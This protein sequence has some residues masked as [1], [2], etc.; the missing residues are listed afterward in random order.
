MTLTVAEIAAFL[1]GTVEGDE[2]V[3]ISGI[4][5]IREAGP[6]E[7]SFV[8]NPRYASDVADTRAGAVIVPKDWAKPAPC[9]LIRVDSPDRAFALAAERF[10][11]PPIR[12]EPGVHST[13]VV[14]PDVKL[15]PSVHVGPHCVIEPGCRIGTGCVLG[16]GVYLGHDCRL[17]DEVRLYPGVSVRERCRLGHRVI[18]HNGAVIGSD[19]FGYSVDEH[20]VRTKI[21]QIGIVE[22]GDDVEIGAN[23]TIDRARFGRTVIGRGTKIDNLVQIAHN[24]VIGENSVIV[25]QVGI[26]GSTSLGARTILGGQVG[27]IGHVKLG[28]GVIVGAQA[29]VTKN[30]PAGSFVSGYPAMPHARATRIQ[31]L[32]Q[33]LPEWRDQ[34]ADLEKRLSALEKKG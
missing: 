9:T 28:D 32:T 4:A 1:N 33:C 16:A 6:R 14:A 34:L 17:G 3:E 26:A 2:A 30:I 27:V 31:A 15:D 10:A 8:A 18:V 19:G 7:I 13:A 25:A 23:T 11:P 20:G 24:V 29:G 22:I 5:G 12:F 21:P